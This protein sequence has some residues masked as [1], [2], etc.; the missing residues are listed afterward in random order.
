MM[1]KSLINRAIRKFE[2]EKEKEDESLEDT[3]VITAIEGLQK[4]PEEKSGGL[5]SRS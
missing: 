3:G 1:D 5:M 2:Q 4:E